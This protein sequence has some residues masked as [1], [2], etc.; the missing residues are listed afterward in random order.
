MTD[1]KRIDYRVQTNWNAFTWRLAGWISEISELNLSDPDT[2]QS[3]LDVT[4]CV[5]R[6]WTLLRLVLQKGAL[7]FEKLS[8]QRSW[9]SSHWVPPRNASSATLSF[10]KEEKEEIEFLWSL[11]RL[12]THIKAFSRGLVLL[13]VSSAL[14]RHGNNPAKIVPELLKWA[15][16]LSD[17]LWKWYCPIG[18]S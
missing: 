9:S 17:L 15:A 5:H 2:L 12:V 3:F 16:C 7:T 1:R 10:K 13:N 8:H 14:L 11:I 6:I 4:F 18:T